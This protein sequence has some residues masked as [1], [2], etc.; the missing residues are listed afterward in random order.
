L[1]HVGTLPG[2]SMEVASTMTMRRINFMSL[3]ET[4]WL[5]EKAKE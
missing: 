3:Q 4:K 5:G 1:E 2:K